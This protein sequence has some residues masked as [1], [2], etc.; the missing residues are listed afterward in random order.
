MDRLTCTVLFDPLGR[1]GKDTKYFSQ[2]LHNSICH[3][4]GL[5][6]LDVVFQPQK[7]VFNALEDSDE[8]TSTTV[9]SRSSLIYL[10]GHNDQRERINEGCNG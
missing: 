7:D 1:D 3:S 10:E 2:D 6:E 4:G 5:R 9:N 8:Y